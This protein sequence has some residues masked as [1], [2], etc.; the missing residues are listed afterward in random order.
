MKLSPNCSRITCQYL[1]RPPYVS[2]DDLP[3][4]LYHATFNQIPNNCNKG[5]RKKRTK[6]GCGWEG[7]QS[8]PHPFRITCETILRRRFA[9]N[10]EGNE[11]RTETDLSRSLE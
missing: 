10:E 1:Q 11:R 2:R 3:M 5:G 8:V 6:K 9:P 7:V 4:S